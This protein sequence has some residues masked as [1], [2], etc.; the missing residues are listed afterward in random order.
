MKSKL[1]QEKATERANRLKRSLDL[2][3]HPDF[4]KS[5]GDW[6]G[7]PA[8]FYVY[9]YLGQDVRLRF[10]Q[11][12]GLWTAI[13]P[14][15]SLENYF[16]HGPPQYIALLIDSWMGKNINPAQVELAK[17]HKVSAAGALEIYKER[18]SL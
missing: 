18:A 13:C 8:S 12:T 15:L 2:S 17:R 11:T 16:R 14:A 4:E 1:S 3:R 9:T 6:D 10:S 7:S 5:F